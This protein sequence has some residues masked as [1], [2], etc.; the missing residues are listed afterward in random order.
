MSTRRRKTDRR[1]TR[2]KGDRPLPLLDPAPNR[3]A[4]GRMRWERDDEQDQ[5]ER[6]KLGTID[7]Q[8]KTPKVNPC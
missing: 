4:D 1:R 7:Q 5:A 3:L 8:P 6:D 2:R